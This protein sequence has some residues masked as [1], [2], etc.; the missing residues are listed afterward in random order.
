[1][2]GEGQGGRGRIRGGNDEKKR[3]REG[4]REEATF[5]SPAKVQG[6]STSISGYSFYSNLSL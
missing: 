4:E 5:L 1:M 3:G 6:K 2:E